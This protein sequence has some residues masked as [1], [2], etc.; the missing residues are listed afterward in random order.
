MFEKTERGNQEWTTKDTD[1]IGHKTQNEDK[2][3]NMTHK[4]EK[5]SNMY[6]LKNG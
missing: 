2:Q 4:T 3:K 1:N 5:M 6:P